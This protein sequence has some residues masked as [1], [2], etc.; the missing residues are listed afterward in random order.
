MM[1]TF[2]LVV[3]MWGQTEDGTWLYIGNQAV[4]NHEFSYEQCEKI[5]ADESWTKW[6]DNQYYDVQFDCHEK[7][8]EI[9]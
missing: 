7:G 8:T 5:A 3:T 2:L 1:K 6:M 4:L 9:K